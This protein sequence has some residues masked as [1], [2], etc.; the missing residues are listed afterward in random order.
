[1]WVVDLVQ[2]LGKCNPNA[3]EKYREQ[4]YASISAQINFIVD[5]VIM[6]KVYMHIYT[7][8]CYSQVNC[9]NSYYSTD[10]ISS[11]QNLKNILGQIEIAN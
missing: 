8:V 10:L 4:V 1:M 3:P 6:R 9:E 11:H 7:S 2:V 5:I